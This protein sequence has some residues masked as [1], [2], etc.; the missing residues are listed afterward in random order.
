MCAGSVVWR[1][2][3]GIWAGLELESGSVT[4][5]RD[6]GPTS[7]LTLTGLCFL[8]YLLGLIKRTWLGY[9]NETRRLACVSAPEKIAGGVR[10]CRF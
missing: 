6:R 3:H 9:K 2:E 7:P 10:Q 8:I 4:S 1:R 5:D